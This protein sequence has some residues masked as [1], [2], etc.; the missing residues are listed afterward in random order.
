MSGRRTANLASLALSQATRQGARHGRLLVQSKTSSGILQSIVDLV[1]TLPIHFVVG[2]VN[3]LAPGTATVQFSETVSKISLKDSLAMAHVKIGRMWRPSPLERRIA[4]AARRA[5]EQEAGRI[6]WP[7]LLEARQKYVAWEAFALWVRA[8]EHAEAGR[9]EWL[10]KIVDKRCRDF[11]KFVAEKKLDHPKGAP[12]FWYHLRCWINERIFGKVWQ[13]GWMSAVGY[14]AARDLT[15]QRNYAYWEYCEDTWERSK[16]AVYPSFRD[17][18]KA[19]EHC[20]DQVLDECEM[21][22]E[23][24]QLIKL[25]QRVGPG[26]LSQ[27]VE[28]YIEREVF[29]YW[30]RTALEAC[31]RLP[32][33]V[34]RE[35]KRRCP[36]FLE[37]DDVARAANPAE[38]PHCRFNRL[39]KWIEDH[40]FAEARKR[41]WFDVL[42][43]QVH[44]HPRHSRVTDYWHDWEAGW[45]KRPSVKYPSFTKWRDS[46]DRYTFEPDED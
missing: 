39:T 21:R 42:R 36:G 45:L 19:S 35:V 40:E 4:V 37:A 9:P 27:T 3:T 46:V 1:A 8:I 44:L 43:Y 30:A 2:E 14:Y 15:Y 41:R 28:R 24:R 22:K 26:T 11:L 6:P 25:M 7:R 34:E 33:S 12:F 29:A 17:W 18:L 20:S 16:P 23:K 13:E 10:A 38:E 31:S 5:A 32:V